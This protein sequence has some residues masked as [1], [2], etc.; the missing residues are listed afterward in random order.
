MRR[1]FPLFVLLLSFLLASFGVAQAQ[2]EYRLGLLIYNV[3]LRPT[4]P[5]PAEGATPQPPLPGTVTSAY[6]TIENTTDRDYQLVGVDIV[7]AEMSM[8]H[9][10]TVDDAGVARMRMISALNIPAGETVQ[11]APVGYHAM[12]MNLT[13]DLYPDETISLILTFANDFGTF[14]RVVGAV[15]TDLPPADDGLIV[16]DAEGAPSHTYGYKLGVF[17]DNRTDQAETLIGISSGANGIG[18]I[19]DASP[20]LRDADEIPFEPLEIA[21]HTQIR[22]APEATYV[23]V[24]GVEPRPTDAL[25]LTLIFASGKTITVAAPIFGAVS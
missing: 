13:R 14:D 15:V 16:A 1:L 3:W 21:P 10:T 4:A 8:L 25:P 23:Y 7:F 5:A 12:L 19:T 24:S 20:T 17:I 6:M 18:I 22:L 11:L 2:P 9:Q